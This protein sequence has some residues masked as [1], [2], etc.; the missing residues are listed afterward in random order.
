MIDSDVR[1]AAPTTK[2]KAAFQNEPKDNFI[3]AAQTAQAKISSKYWGLELPSDTKLVLMA[4]EWLQLQTGE[5]PTAEAIAHTCCLPAHQARRC[6][7]E[8]KVGGHL[9]AAGGTL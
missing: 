4:V 5:T 7:Y 2:S 9:D 1:K 6:L 8:L 3:P